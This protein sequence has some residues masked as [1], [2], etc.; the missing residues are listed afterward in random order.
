M[1]DVIVDH[2]GKV[3]V[4]NM[5]S[6]VVPSASTSPGGNGYE[7]VQAGWTDKQGCRRWC[8]GILSG[9]YRVQQ[10]ISIYLWIQR[11]GP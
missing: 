7:S 2:L 11:Y 6:Q 8:G 3:D 4:K 1:I 10:G 9:S 5:V